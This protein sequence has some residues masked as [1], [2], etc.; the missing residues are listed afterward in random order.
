[1]TM[2]ALRHRTEDPPTPPNPGLKSVPDPEPEK[3]PVAYRLT[4]IYISVVL[5]AIFIILVVDSIR[6]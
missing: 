3:Q 6:R 4:M 1:M 2:I 5:T